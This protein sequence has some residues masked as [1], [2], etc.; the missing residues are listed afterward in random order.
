M[1]SRPG[2]LYNASAHA[3]STLAQTRRMGQGPALLTS[4]IRQL[5]TQPCFKAC[6]ISAI[7][8]P[9][10]IHQRRIQHQSPVHEQRVICR[11]AIR[12]T[13]TKWSS[14][15]L[16]R[17]RFLNTLTIV[18]SQV[19]R[20]FLR[21]L[22]HRRGRSFTLRF[23]QTILQ[24]NQTHR[25]QLGERPRQGFVFVATGEVASIELPTERILRMSPLFEPSVIKDE[26]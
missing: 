11:R 18:W 4:L 21:N 24:S 5:L 25:P 2:S 14:M 15:K 26:T 1:I 3:A 10:N 6:P 22:L 12:I 8:E 7:L 19:R 23:L 17:E 9:T 13:T 16:R 20:W